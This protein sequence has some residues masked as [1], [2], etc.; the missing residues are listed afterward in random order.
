MKSNEMIA[1]YVDAYLQ[2]LGVFVM[3]NCGYIL[4]LIKGLWVHVASG[5]PERVS[6]RK[7]VSCRAH[8]QAERVCSMELEIHLASTQG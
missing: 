6:A 2:A 1:N 4:L 7:R 3:F 5:M 8:E